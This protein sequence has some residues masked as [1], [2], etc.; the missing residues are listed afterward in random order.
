MSSKIKKF[1]CNSCGTEFDAPR[2]IIRNIS[3][4]DYDQEVCPNCEGHDYH[5]SDRY[6]TYKIQKDIR[7]DPTIKYLWGQ[8]TSNTS[9]IET[10]EG[11]VA[12]LNCLLGLHDV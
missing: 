2:E 6:R 10:L 11:E 12:T 7:E 9:R 3:G 1:Q 5:I 4:K 8:I